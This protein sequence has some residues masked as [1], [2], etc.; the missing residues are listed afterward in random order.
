MLE[1]FLDHF[2]TSFADSLKI[3]LPIDSPPVITRDLAISSCVEPDITHPVEYIFRVKTSPMVA[4]P[5][6]Q[7]PETT[8]T[9]GHVQVRLHGSIDASGPDHCSGWINLKRGF[10][11]GKSYEMSVVG[12]DVGHVRQI[13]LKNKSS[14]HWKPADVLVRRLAVGSPD[15]WVE[16]A[17]GA[18]SLGR[19]DLPK[20]S[21]LPEKIPHSVDLKTGLLN[22]KKLYSEFSG[23]FQLIFMSFLRPFKAPRRSR[24]RPRLSPIT[25][26]ILSAVI[27]KRRRSS[28]HAHF[29][30]FFFKPFT[31]D[32]YPLRSKRHRG[33]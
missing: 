23:N 32:E 30:S 4:P 20:A 9:Q 31:F 17:M 7:M 21:F 33:N 16:F 3:D 26:E 10:V 18:K 24:Y 22:L 14:Q 8:G 11:A 5:Q 15:P 2:W 1:H 29:K 12:P 27:T 13:D 6:G 28:L 19:P 25:E